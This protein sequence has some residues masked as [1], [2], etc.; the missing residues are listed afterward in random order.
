MTT[1]IAMPTQIRLSL[2]IDTIAFMGSILMALSG[3]SFLVFPANDTLSGLHAYGGVMT[4]AAIV[5]HIALHWQWIKTMARRSVETLV[6]KNVKL[7]KSV[8]LNLVMDT[9]IAISFLVT[10]I[11]GVLLD[12]RSDISGDFDGRPIGGLQGRLFGN[13]LED[14]P[15]NLSGRLM[16]GN[17]SRPSFQWEALDLIHLWAV[18]ALISL[19]FIHIW[20]HW[21]WI[22]NVTVRFIGSMRR[23]TGLSGQPVKVGSNE[24]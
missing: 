20:L 12:Q 7:P 15:G 5:I 6:S 17:V 14:S 24:R 11:S 4:I 1:Q 21:R 13:F 22:T 3:I 18:I 16:Q 19:F 2:L 10:A 8:R 9:L 23:Q